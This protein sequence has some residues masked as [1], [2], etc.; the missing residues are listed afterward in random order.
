MKNR[1]PS[2]D[3]KSTIGKNDIPTPNKQGASTN[4]GSSGNLHAVAKAESTKRKTRQI[5]GCKYILLDT[6]IYIILS[7]FYSALFPIML[8]F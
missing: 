1:A 8:A 5:Q 6:T 4:K 2:N 7:S 3:G